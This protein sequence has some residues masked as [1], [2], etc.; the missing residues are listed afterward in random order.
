MSRDIFLEIH[1]GLPPEGSG[2]LKYTRRAFHMLPA[3]DRSRI[4][5]V[6]CGR[7]EP[8]LELTR[9][10]QGQVVGVDTDKPS[11]D[12]LA[13]KIEEAGLSDRVQAVKCSMFAMAFPDESFDIIWAEGSIFIIG[14]ERGL[15]KWRRLIKPNGYLVVHEMV[16]LRSD[17]PP[18]IY[19]CWKA[20]YSGITTAPENLEQIPTC[21]YYLVGHFTLPEDAWW[22]EYY[23]PLETRIQELRKKYVRDSKALAV[24]D[25]EQREID[26]FKKC[27]K[28]YGSAF[29]VMQRRSRESL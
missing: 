24:L 27:R 11:L 16:W 5:D 26:T 12:I 22:T 23:R 19:N 4:L 3:L 14:F 21:G 29:F 15:V 25:R 10:S 13:R 18:E 17:P 20:R 28:W 1:Q 8:T 9:L 6:G 2:R 7:G